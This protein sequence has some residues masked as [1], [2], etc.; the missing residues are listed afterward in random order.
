MCLINNQSAALFSASNSDIS[1]YGDT[2][3]EIINESDVE[4]INAEI[5]RVQLSQ[6]KALPKPAQTV[7][8]LLEIGHPYILFT[9]KEDSQNKVPVKLL[10]PAVIEELVDVS[11]SK[12]KKQLFV[13]LSLPADFTHVGRLQERLEKRGKLYDKDSLVV[14][15]CQAVSDKINQSNKSMDFVWRSTNGSATICC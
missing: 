15:T 12:N 8:Y 4:D 3:Y 13:K 6:T 14:S 7:P 2:D 10:V 1:E 9:Y 5:N 11:L